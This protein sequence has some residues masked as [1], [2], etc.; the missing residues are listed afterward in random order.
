MPPYR[1]KG[2]PTEMPLELEEVSINLKELAHYLSREWQD[3]FDFPLIDKSD[4]ISAEFMVNG[5]H[6]SLT[7]QVADGDEITIIPYIGGG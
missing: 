2:A 4:I 6:Q 3:K 1:K 7:Y 5:K